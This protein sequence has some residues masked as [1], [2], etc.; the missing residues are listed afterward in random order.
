MDTVDEGQADQ[1]RLDTET[2]LK[3]EYGAAYQDR[4]TNGNAVLQEFGAEDI[5]EIQL[6]DGRLLGDHP[7]MIK[8]MVNIGEFINNKI[9]EDSLEGIKTSGAMTPG[10]AQEKLS[11]LIAPSSPYWDQRHPEHQFYVDEALRI[12]EMMSG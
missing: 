4:M 9:G 6:S 12:R 5:T 2:E 10:D 8:M 1:I 11:E 3:R 7:D